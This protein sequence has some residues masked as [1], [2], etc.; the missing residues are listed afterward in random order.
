MTAN[1][2]AEIRRSAASPRI[3]AITAQQGITDRPT[4][5]VTG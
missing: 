5:I 1:A 2:Y 3:A 4:A